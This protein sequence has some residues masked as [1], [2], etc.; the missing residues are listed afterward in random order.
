VGHLDPHKA[1]G[2]VG[3]SVGDHCGAV[4][5]D[6]SNVLLD[7]VPL[8]KVRRSRRTS[9]KAGDPWPNDNRVASSTLI[10]A[11]SASARIRMGATSPAI[12]TCAPLRA[13]LP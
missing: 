9:L 11:T 10:C 2:G 5:S 4:R 13:I 12:V 3:R 7:R 1:S 8:R 6:E